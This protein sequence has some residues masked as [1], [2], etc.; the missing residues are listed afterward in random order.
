[1]TQQYLAGELSLLL[2]QLR[3]VMTNPASADAV[4]A[5]RREAEHAPVPELAAITR[6]ALTLSDSE[7]WES[8]TRGHTAAFVRQ[9]EVSEQLYELGLCAGW[10]DGV[11]GGFSSSPER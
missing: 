5:L 11:G 3:S 6:H 8:L 10:S 4:A 1:M 2:A 7:C 9:T